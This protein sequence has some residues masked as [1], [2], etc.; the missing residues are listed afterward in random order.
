MSFIASSLISSLSYFVPFSASC[1]LAPSSSVLSRFFLLHHFGL[2]SG[3]CVATAYHLQDTVPFPPPLPQH[4]GPASNGVLTFP[5]LD[6]S[7]PGSSLHY[8]TVYIWREYV[9][10]GEQEIESITCVSLFIPS[11]LWCSEPSGIEHGIIP[12]LPGAP[13]VII[14]FIDGSSRQ[15]VCVANRSSSFFFPLESENISHGLRK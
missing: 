4:V 5:C 12:N 15:R 1:L 2:A 14:I 13:D 3:L 8:N 6:D 7:R 11:S 10:Q 9:R